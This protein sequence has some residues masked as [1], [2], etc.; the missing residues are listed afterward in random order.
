MDH[1]NHTGLISGLND[2]QQIKM[3]VKAAQKMVGSATMQLDP[4]AIQRAE[5]AIQDAR[6]IMNRSQH[7]GYDEDF[8]QEQSSLLQ[9]CEHQ[10]SEA[11][12]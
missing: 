4:E 10:L 8:I 1:I 6:N 9:Q 11:Q 3:S 12:Q 2:I 5:E 7:T